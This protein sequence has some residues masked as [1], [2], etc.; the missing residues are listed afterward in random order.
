MNK[1]KRKGKSSCHL[2]RRVSAGRGIVSGCRTHSATCFKHFHLL[3]L[4]TSQCFKIA[5]SGRPCLLFEDKMRVKRHIFSTQTRPKSIF[6][7][8]A[9]R[10]NRPLQQPY[11]KNTTEDGLQTTY[12]M[13]RGRR[14]TLLLV[15]LHID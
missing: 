15:I 8:F 5:T 10:G 7:S 2:L 14:R 11:I 9:F 1:K 3:S 12:K 4:K 6:F 13:R